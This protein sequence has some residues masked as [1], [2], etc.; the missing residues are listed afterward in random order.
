MFNFN[1]FRKPKPEIQTVETVMRKF[2]AAQQGR[3][4]TGWGGFN[5][6]AN[7][8]NYDITN[9]LDF[10]KSRSRELVQ[11]SSLINSYVGVMERNVIGSQGITFKA[12]AGLAD[13]KTDEFA[14]RIL[15]KQW[16][17]FSKDPCLEGNQ[18]LSDFLRLVLKI[19]LVDGEV[20][21]IKHPLPEGLRLEIVDSILLD[22]TLNMEIDKKII[23]GIEVDTRNRPKNYYFKNAQ[24]LTNIRDTYTIV[25]AKDVIHVF[26]KKFAG[27]MRGFPEVA[28]AAM[29]LKG[30][31][32]YINSEIIAAIVSS[33]LT[34]FITQNEK[35][36]GIQIGEKSGNQK[37]LKV[38][39]GQ[40]EELKQGQGW[41]NAGPAAHPTTAFE[42]FT[43]S[44]S[45]MICA[46]LGVSVNQISGDWESTSFSSARAAH[47]SDSETFRFYQK[48]LVERILFPVYSEW[49]ELEFVRG[50]IPFL[51]FS[52]IERYKDVTFLPRTWE[53]VDKVGQMN[54]YEKQLELKLTSRQR[55]LAEQGLDIK[56]IDREIAEDGVS[57]KT[58]DGEK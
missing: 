33:S 8:I 35:S 40:I 56:D 6:T 32:Q 39:P 18:S 28:S 45:K 23:N 11:N 12:N 15:E 34:G 3:L 13:G 20:V 44:V 29:D 19:I 22:S 26:N 14:K 1:F 36:D 47:L 31:D 5:V 53:W 9:E 24:T 43:K 27:Q 58:D 10:L 25:S 48:L 7:G 38:R 41:Q 42:P 46:S 21:I 17:K 4:F 52:N 51:D 50:G 30:L 57:V 16:E 54:A 37:F 49:L 2:E 55:I